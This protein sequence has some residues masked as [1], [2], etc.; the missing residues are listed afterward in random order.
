MSGSPKPMKADAGMAIH[1]D[2]WF[3]KVKAGGFT[4]VA[5]PFAYKV[6]SAKFVQD[7][8][9]ILEVSGESLFPHYP[10]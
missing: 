7:E 10:K 5:E 8:K 9:P 2:D 6:Y 4:P 1:D 3:K